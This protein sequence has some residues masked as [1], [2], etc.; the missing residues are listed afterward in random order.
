MKINLLIFLLILPLAFGQTPKNVQKTTGT[1]AITEDLAFPSGKTLTI[2][3][4][5]SLTLESGVTLALPGV[6]D[7][8]FITKTASGTLTNEFALGS[9]ATGILKNTTTTGVPT[10]ATA[11][12][13]YIAPGSITGSGLTM[14]T[15]RLLGRTTASTGAIEEITIGAGLTLTGGELAASGGGG[16]S[17]DVVGPGSATDNALARFDTTTGKLIQNSN[18]TLADS[19]SAFVFSNAAGLTAGGSNQDITLTPSGTGVNVLVNGFRIGTASSSALT[20]GPIQIYG[21]S[22]P[23]ASFGMRRGSAD[24]FGP[25][26][27]FSKSRGSIA[28][29]SAV[30]SGDQIGAF[31]GGGYD[32]SA[33]SDFRAILKFV[34]TQNWSSGNTGSSI[35]FGTTPN[36]SATRADR[37]KIDQ[38][39]SLAIGVDALS[40]AFTGSSPKLIIPME[41]ASV[42]QNF[43]IASS[44]NTSRGIVQAFRS[45]GSL[46]SPSAA[47]SGDSVFSFLFG[48]HSGSA[49]EQTAELA[50]FVD[51]SVSSGNVPMRLEFQTGA[52]N[53]AS[54]AAR[55]TIKSGGEVQ[56]NSF[57]TLPTST[58]ASASAAGVAG[59]ITWDASYIYVCT[60][61]NTWKRAALTTW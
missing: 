35:V 8:G 38:D 57:L 18:V 39:G 54:R 12:T 17:G 52:T 40:S 56:V 44:T 48:A 13:D 27:G 41:N 32:G 36:N 1:N 42:V 26:V 11:G 34:A 61:T 5:G 10:I 20:T 3:T 50:A 21:S 45:R 23:T 51:G 59:T 58:P 25:Y 15:A 53:A 49:I 46:A 37:V 16:G 31:V 43:S 28:S 6:L 14:A 9:L 7:A 19:G 22:D 4:G 60:A 33:H 29:P 47:T 2:K 24:A 55:L 30:Q